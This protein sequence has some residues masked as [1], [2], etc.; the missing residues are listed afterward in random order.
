[1]I[2]HGW[3]GCANLHGHLSPDAIREG[4]VARSFPW[5][6]TGA[7]IKLDTRTVAK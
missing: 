2:M 4:M 6:V 1:V 7:W 5:A 3:V